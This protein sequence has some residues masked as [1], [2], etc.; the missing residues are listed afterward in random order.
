MNA[1]TR[2]RIGQAQITVSIDVSHSEL[3]TDFI[4]EAIPAGFQ[5]IDTTDS[6]TRVLRF[7]LSE[8]SV[9][10]FRI[11][12]RRFYQSAFSLPAPALEIDFVSDIDW[13]ERFRRETKAVIVADSI[14]VRPTWVERESVNVTGVTI[15]IV[16][17]PK[18]AFGVGS[19]ETTQLAMCALKNN[20]REG[21]R[22]ADIGCGS[23]ILSI[24][25]VKL[26]AAYVKAID[27]DPVAIENSNENLR[28]NQVGDKVEIA[29][30]SMDVISEEN[31]S[32][33]VVVANIIIHKLL[34]LLADLVKLVK[35]NGTLILSGVM[36]RDAQIFETAM[37]ELGV[38]TWQQ[39]R[40]G[41]WVC[42]VCSP[43]GS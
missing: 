10:S 2:P 37:R 19:H 30:G 6:Q 36:E 7:Y 32:Y 39:S 26:G 24:L 12:W 31:G 22:V 21:Q 41:E 17:D 14:L 40:Q 33:D 8:S 1:N 28:L 16:I 13:Q 3:V 38:T 18:M 15:D 5:E 34:N 4:T 9:D 29:L 20:V 42:Y 35:S 27:N 43:T 11:A 23:S 25:A